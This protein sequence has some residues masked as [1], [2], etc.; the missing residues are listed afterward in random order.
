VKKNKTILAVAVVA[1][2]GAISFFGYRWW[3]VRNT[4]A[5]EELLA[6]MPGD[7]EKIL[8]A[9]VSVL[10]QSPFVARL[11]AWAPKTQ[12]DADYAQ[13]VRDTGFDYER[14]LDRIAVASYKKSGRSTIFAVA[15]GRFDKKK[16]AAYAQ[17]HGKIF[18]TEWN[19]QVFAVPLS[20]SKSTLCFAFVRS[21]EIVITDD[22]SCADKLREATRADSRRADWQPRFER[23]GGSPVFAVVRQDGATGDALAAQ[24]PGGLRSPRLSA[25]LNQLQWITIAGIPQ[26]ST[27]RVVTECEAASDTTT[28]QLADVLNGLILFAQVGLN[29]PKT[30]QQVAPEARQAYLELLNSAEISRIDRNQTKSVRIV[31]EVTP[32]ILDAAKT[33]APGVPG[34]SERVAPQSKGT[35]KN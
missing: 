27:L 22:V 30:R 13:F 14:D 5:R 15:S 24:A 29:D 3:S 17:Q 35:T 23:L 33:V 32:K 20:D 25:L 2:L 11:I 4:P 16:I 1:I 18:A 12:A 28:Q 9:D 31:L 34:A 6:G 10:R 26:E 21:D 8:Y 7:A 19:T